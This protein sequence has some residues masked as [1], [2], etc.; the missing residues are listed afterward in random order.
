MGE[1]AKQKSLIKG[2]V[3]GERTQKEQSVFFKHG[4]FENRSIYFQV[5][6]SSLE[7]VSEWAP[8]KMY[9]PYLV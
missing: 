5:R 3:E 8:L 9:L 1:N 6:V 4:L 2:E 7:D